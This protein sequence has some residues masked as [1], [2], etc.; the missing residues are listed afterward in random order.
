M[1]DEERFCRL[2][3]FTDAFTH[4]FYRRDFLADFFS[5]QFG[6]VMCPEIRGDGIV[7]VA[8]VLV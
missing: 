5:T 6:N 3:R 1:L 4:P 7:L 2:G 8:L